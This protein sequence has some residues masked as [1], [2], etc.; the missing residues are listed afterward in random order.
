MSVHTLIKLPYKSVAQTLLLSGAYDDDDEEQRELKI[1]D[2]RYIRFWFD[3]TSGKFLPC[4]EWTDPAWLEL[5]SKGQERQ[6][7]ESDERMR[8][9]LLFGKNQIDIQEK[10]IAQLLVEEVNF[11]HPHT[12]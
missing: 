10:S 4:S 8:R 3:S 1:L 6:G 9:G 7:L 11:N 5:R 2:Y 12:S